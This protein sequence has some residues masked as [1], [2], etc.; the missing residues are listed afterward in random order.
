MASSSS[1]RSSRFACLR[2]VWAKMVETLSLRILEMRPETLFEEVLDLIAGKDIIKS[3]ETY[4]R[5]F[6][7]RVTMAQVREALES[8]FKQ[9]ANESVEKEFL[10]LEATVDDDDIRVSS[11]ADAELTR[12]RLQLKKELKQDLEHRVLEAERE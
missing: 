2:L 10:A 11:D 1:R 3:I 9:V 6:M 4:V 5:L 12:Y 8:R 7:F